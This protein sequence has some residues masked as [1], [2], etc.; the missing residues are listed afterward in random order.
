MAHAAQPLR[1]KQEISDPK[2]GD[3][4]RR[5]GNETSR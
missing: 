4:L 2:N 5:T 1:V 3:V